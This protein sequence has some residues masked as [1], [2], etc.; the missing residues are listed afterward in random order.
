VKLGYFAQ[1]RGD[2]LNM[3]HTV[4]QSAMDLPSRPGENLARTLLGSFL[5]RGDDVFK[6]VGILSG[7]EKSRLAL[8]RLLLDPPNLL[9]MDEPTTHLDMGSIDALIG[10]L[11]DFE[12]TLVFISHDVHF[13]RAMARSVIHIAGGVLTP[14]AGD[15][16]YFLDKTKSTS[17][18]EALTA[19]LGNFQ[20]DLLPAPVKQQS[21][22]GG[23]SKEQKRLEAEAR[24]ARSRAKKELEQKIQDIEARS[25]AL[26]KRRSELHT[27]LRSSSAYA[28]GAK[29]TD[30]QR[31]LDQADRQ[32]EDLTAQWERATAELEALAPTPAA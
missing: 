14:Y 21:T 7:G 29:A 1:Y 10:A 16:Q 23:K 25:A 9:L 32:V 15:Y 13:I 18:R 11:E 19:K 6:P 8:V 3:K 31:E 4:V 24:N 5:F 17:A 27:I 26:E 22:P 12:G 20:P 2:V 28:D 30:L